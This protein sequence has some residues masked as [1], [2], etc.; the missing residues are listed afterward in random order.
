M[1][2][3]RSPLAIKIMD[4][5]PHAYENLVVEGDTPALAHEMLSGVQPEQLLSRP[6]ASPVAAF[7]MLA[8]LWLWHDGLDEC[9]KIA[10][11]SPEELH[12][13]ALNLHSK[14]SKM[15]ENG[16]SVQSVEN[17][18]TIN[19]SELQQMTSTMAF[20]P[21]TSRDTD[22]TSSAWESRSPLG[23]SPES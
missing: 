4:A 20:W 5:N 15:Y 2:D 7:A 23:E 16:G 18:K 19:H 11:K 22:G 14:A 1:L 8:G 13:S 3:V 12:H 9:H 6:A 10:Q 21:S 17:H